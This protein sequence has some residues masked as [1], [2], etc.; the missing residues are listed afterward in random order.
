ML[1]L[2]MHEGKLPSS[3]RFHAVCTHL[4]INRLPGIN[5]LKMICFTRSCRNVSEIMK[6]VLVKSASDVF[7]RVS[8]CIANTNNGPEQH[9]RRLLQIL[10]LP[11]HTDC[12][13]NGFLYLS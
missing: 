13:V 3:V 2:E 10:D 1:G 7:P 6:P 5:T 8:V 11:V 9:Q 12:F 4:L